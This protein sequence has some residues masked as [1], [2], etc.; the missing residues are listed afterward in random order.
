[1]T[2]TSIVLLAWLA[3]TV[4]HAGQPQ[5]KVTVYLLDRANDR[6]MVA[7]RPKRWPAECSPRLASLWSGPKESPPANLRSRPSS[8][9]W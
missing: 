8:S 4:A 5:R 7:S 1:M 3:G 9:N 2:T 6:Y